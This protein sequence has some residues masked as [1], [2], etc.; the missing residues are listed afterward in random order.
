MD[1]IYQIKDTITELKYIG[2][3]KNWQGPGTYWGSP[4]CK[5]KRCKKF[6]L[7]Q[8]WKE[9]LSIRKESFEFTILEQFDDIPHKTLLETELRWQKYF[10]VLSDPTFINASYA[11]KGYLGNIY[12]TF[13][14]EEQNLIKEKIRNSIV[15]RYGR[16]ST[17]EK[18]KLYGKTGSTNPNFDNR[19]S[20]SQR[21][22]LSEKMKNYY[23][24]NSNYKKGRKFEEIYGTEK[25]NSIK[26]IMR[27][28]ILKRGISGEKNPFYGGKHSEETRERMKNSWAKRAIS[29][30]MVDNVVFSGATEASRIFNM[31]RTTI[32]N[33]C[34]NKKFPTW[35]FLNDSKESLPALAMSPDIKTVE[36]IE[37][38]ILEDYKLVGYEPDSFIKFPIAV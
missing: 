10:N 36:D 26:Q 23:K 28:K 1:I 14:I 3:K 18:K 37:N 34:K 16:M 8:Q 15:E 32:F 38:S 5:S 6:L 30:I 33:R 19:W 11:K 35:I 13:S 29:K 20:D 7:Q 12:E 24:T 21:K 4:N 31:P 25:S 2:S 9:A 22:N 27:E 17:E